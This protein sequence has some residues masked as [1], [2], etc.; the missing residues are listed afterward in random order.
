MVYDQSASGLLGGK[1][2]RD[3]AGGSSH[4]A[5]GVWAG[6]RGRSHFSARERTRAGDG[7]FPFWAWD[8]CPSGIRDGADSM[9]FIVL[10]SSGQF[11]VL[12]WVTRLTGRLVRWHF[13]V[14]KYSALPLL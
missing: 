7:G 2:D 3:L 13:F 11:W 1:Q 12:D 10:G 4:R 14:A 5:W 8:Y 6:T 9:N